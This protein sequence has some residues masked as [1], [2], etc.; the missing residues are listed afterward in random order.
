MK[1]T[2]LML[3]IFTAASLLFSA[4][5]AADSGIKAGMD[6]TKFNLSKKGVYS[7]LTNEKTDNLKRLRFGV[8]HNFGITE[9]VGVQVEAYYVQKGSEIKGINDDKSITSN[10]KLSYIELPVLLKL[11]IPSSTVRFHL[12]G[13]GYAAYRLTGKMYTTTKVNGKKVGSQVE[14]KVKD[15]FKKFDFGITVGAGVSVDL[16]AASLILEARYNHGLANIYDVKNSNVKIKNRAFSFMVG[17]G[18]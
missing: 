5:L 8:F 10:T 13:G 15:D 14:T 16:N 3:I 11:T 4:T 1:K 2:T 18:F 12:L 7:G 17:F 6:L 9:S